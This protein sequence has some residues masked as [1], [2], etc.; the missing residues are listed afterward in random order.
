M[1]IPGPAHE[2]SSSL[3]RSREEHLSWALPYPEHEEMVID[4]LSDEEAEAFLTAVAD[5]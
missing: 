2:H 1:S 5:A 3:E 4:G